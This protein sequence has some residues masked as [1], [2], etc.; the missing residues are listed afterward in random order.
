MGSS[1]HPHPHDIQEHVGWE[2]CPDLSDSD[3][4]ESCGNMVS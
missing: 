1:P 4:H 3:V 2:V